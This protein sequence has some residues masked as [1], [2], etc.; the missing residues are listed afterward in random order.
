MKMNNEREPEIPVLSAT[1][2]RMKFTLEWLP[3]APRQLG[4][5]EWCLIQ[6]VVICDGNRIVEQCYKNLPEALDLIHNL[7]RTNFEEH[8]EKQKG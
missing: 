7:V 8:N 6:D 3:D 2:L 4:D 5:G 1:K